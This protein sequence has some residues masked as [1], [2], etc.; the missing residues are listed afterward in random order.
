[1]R[2]D[3][4]LKELEIATGAVNDLREIVKRTRLGRLDLDK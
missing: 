2:K 3:L 1:M 4:D